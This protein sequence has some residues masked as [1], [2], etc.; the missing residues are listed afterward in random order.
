MLSTLKGWTSA[1]TVAYAAIA[2]ASLADQAVGGPGSIS[3]GVTAPAFLMGGLSFF[4]NIIFQVARA[5]PRGSW[6]SKDEAL[7]K[8]GMGAA[9]LSAS[10]VS[11][12]SGTTA[13][14]VAFDAGLL[15]TVAWSPVKRLLSDTAYSFKQKAAVLGAGVAGL[16]GLAMAFTAPGPQFE[17]FMGSAC[18]IHKPLLFLAQSALFLT[19]IAVVGGSVKAIH[20]ILKGRKDEGS[21]T[22]L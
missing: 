15:A 11:Y 1:D 16:P 3:V 14:L 10:A 13:S 19:G 22:G 8:V 9:F 5:D 6:L 12:A 21:Q 2:A 18:D 7:V 20:S 4:R 17:Q